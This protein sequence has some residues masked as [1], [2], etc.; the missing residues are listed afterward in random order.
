MYAPL[1]EGKALVFF[2]VGQFLSHVQLFATPWT[3]A[4]HTSLSIISWHLLKLMSIELVISSNISFSVIPFS[5]CLQ[6]LPASGSSPVSQFFK[7][8]GQSIGASASALVLPVNIQDWFPLGLT[9]WISLQSKGLSR[10]FSNT[11][12][13]KHQFFSTQL[14]LWSNSHIHTWP[15]EKP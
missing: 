1:F 11:T 8:G 5:S 13:Q 2:V 12:L 14:S 15:L 7:S 3:A 9:G 10:V 6:S 4:C